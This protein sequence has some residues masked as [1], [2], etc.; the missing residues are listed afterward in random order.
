[1]RN[2]YEQTQEFHARFH[3][4]A[5][6]A[7][8]ALTAEEAS[9]R[10]EFMVEE[11]VEFL[12]ATSQGDETVF[13]ELMTR[14]RASVD[15]AEDKV[16]P[17]LSATSPMLLGQVDA[18]TD[19]LYFTYGTFVLM[20]VEP[21]GIFEIVHQANMGKVFP[22]GQAHYHPSTGKVLKPDNWAQEFAPEPRIEAELARQ[23][24]QASTK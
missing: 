18:L 14:L 23:T 7:P 12:Q 15:K 21:L 5:V 4:P 10:A 9:Y 6:T 13:G 16:R 24:A 20:A 1:M 19:L 2:P 3:P 8:T 17:Q 22:D 11:L